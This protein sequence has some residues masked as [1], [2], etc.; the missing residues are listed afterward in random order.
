MTA[1]AHALIAERAEHLAIHTNV[2]TLGIDNPGAPTDVTPAMHRLLAAVPAPSSDT[3]SVVETGLPSGEMGVVRGRAKSIHLKSSRNSAPREAFI[4]PEGT[5]AHFAPGT[6]FVLHTNGSVIASEPD[7]PDNTAFTNHLIEPQESVSV[8]GPA[9]ISIAPP[10]QP[11]SAIEEGIVLSK[12]IQSCQINYGIGSMLM[13]LIGSPIS[14]GVAIS[15]GLD[16][17]EGATGLAIIAMAGLSIGTGVLGLEWVR[18]RIKKQPAFSK[19]QHA[20]R[21][22]FD[23]NASDIEE[24]A[25]GS[26][27]SVIE[28]NR[29]WAV[30]ASHICGNGKNLRVLAPLLALPAPS[31]TLDRTLLVKAPMRRKPWR[32]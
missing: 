2:A 29:I 17:S 11:I 21:Q 9:V 19:A 31:P 16:L 24:Y 30:P 5:V 13:G 7:R 6:N 32:I 3:I 20:L 18:R 26:D 25:R 14:V 10:G 15:L 8:L 22:I 23:H 4:V 1:R 27:I 12:K 28:H